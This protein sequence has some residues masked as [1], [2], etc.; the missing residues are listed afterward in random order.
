VRCLAG[1]AAR[2]PHRVFSG[3]NDRHVRVWHLAQ[4]LSLSLSL[5]LA[6]KP[7]PNPDAR[8]ACGTWRM[9]SLAATSAEL[10]P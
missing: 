1:G 2:Y 8:C 4:P 3:S 9:S 10:Y 6:L 5:A 7:K